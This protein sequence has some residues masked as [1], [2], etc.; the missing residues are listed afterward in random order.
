MNWIEWGAGREPEEDE[1]EDILA[2]LE[3]WV[4]HIEV[5]EK[6]L[7]EKLEDLNNNVKESQ[8]TKA[9]FIAKMKEDSQKQKSRMFGGR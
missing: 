1:A 8:E 2:K 3:D 9:K 4:T 5:V 7:E 6:R